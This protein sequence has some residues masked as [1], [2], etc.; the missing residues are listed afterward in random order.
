MS[1]EADTLRAALRATLRQPAR[2]RGI[3]DAILPQA[4]ADRAHAITTDPHTPLYH[5]VCTARRVWPSQDAG[6]P[7]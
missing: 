3:V 7:L 1:T 4:L 6:K 5:A 2:G